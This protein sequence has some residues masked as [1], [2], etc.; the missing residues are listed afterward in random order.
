M[1]HDLD[2]ALDR[3]LALL[4]DGESIEGCLGRYPEY[5]DELRPLLELVIQVGQVITPA[6]SPTARAAGERRM[7]DALAQR[8]ERQAQAHPAGLCL[9]RWLR[10]LAG[11]GRRGRKPAWAV[12]AVVLALVL[13]VGGGRAIAGT[14]NSLPGDALYPLK[15]FSQKVQVTL[16]FDPA[17]RERLQVRFREQARRD[18]QRVLR[19]GRQVSV[20]FEG[21]LEQMEGDLWV[22]GGVPV[23]LQPTTIVTGQPYVG[24]LVTVRGDL[25]GDGSVLVTALSV[26]P[27]L[28]P[29]PTETPEPTHTPTPS[30]TA[31]PTSTPTPTRTPSPTATVEPSQTPNPTDTPRWTAT[32]EAT[33]TPEPTQMPRRT[34][35]ATPG[36]SQ[37]Q[38]QESPEPDWTATPGPEDPDDAGETPEP[39]ETPGPEEGWEIPTSAA[40][41]VLT[42]GP[43][44]APKWTATPEPTEGPDPDWTDTPEPTHVPEPTEP[45]EDDDD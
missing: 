18:V 21:V 28:T 15:Q 10:S 35:T 14:A 30:P 40:G 45:H 2:T 43:A 37:P 12:A 11:M 25:P 39:A 27:E 7:L 1:R 6:P 23:T 29:R 24:D 17:E 33:E 5:A 38:E 34:A 32:L 13:V 31:E 22:V 26:G 8:G 20:E 44:E 3:C 16:T 19:G 42:A 4:R 9:R 36:P 41:P